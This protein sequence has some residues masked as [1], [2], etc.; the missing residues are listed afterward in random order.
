MRK[1]KFW[2]KED[3]MHRGVPIALPALFFALNLASACPNPAAD[4]ASLGLQQ[5]STDKTDRKSSAAV[6]KGCLDEQE[7]RY[8]LVSAETMQVLATLEADGFPTEGFAKH[9]GHKVI[10]RGTSIP[11][12]NH[13]V[14]KVRSV[15]TISD[16]CEPG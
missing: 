4:P 1:T 12:G 6:L 5:K 8:V 7:G 16:T 14:F 15:E 11:N 13:P 3:N 10:V 9:V 2:P